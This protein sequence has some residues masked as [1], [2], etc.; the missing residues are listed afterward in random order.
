MRSLLRVDLREHL[1]ASNKP[2]M[3][4]DVPLSQLVKKEEDDSSS[5]D[6]S[7]DDSSDSDGLLQ[8]PN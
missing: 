2:P 3:A 1:K 4:I 7:S 5:S 8:Q 6:D